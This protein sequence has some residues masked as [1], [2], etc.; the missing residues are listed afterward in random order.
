MDSIQKK[1]LLDT[2]ILC[3]A[4]G[5]II[6]VATLVPVVQS[7]FSQVPWPLLPVLLTATWGGALGIRYRRE[8]GFLATII[9]LTSTLAFIL[10][11]TF[12]GLLIDENEFLAISIL[13]V[14]YSTPAFIGSAFLSVLFSNIFS[15]FIK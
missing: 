9:F 2:T 6:P 5:F 11:F 10:M 1:R 7:A 8:V 12:G 14:F 13:F 3:L 15:F 4:G